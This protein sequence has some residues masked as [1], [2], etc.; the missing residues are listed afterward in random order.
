MLFPCCFGLQEQKL[1]DEIDRLNEELRDCDENINRRKSDI[2][3][4]ETL[5]AQS[6]EGLNHYKVERDKLHDER[7]SL[8]GKENELTSEIDKLRAEVEKAEKSLDHAIPGVSNPS[9]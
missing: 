2:T 4:L 8:W 7:K 9:F 6:R 1:L 5:I 3:A